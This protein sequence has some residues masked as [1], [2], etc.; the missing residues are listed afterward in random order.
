[1]ADPNPAPILDRIDHA[2]ARIEAAAAARTANHAALVRRHETLRTRMAEAVGAL[3]A[4]IA[5]ES[6]G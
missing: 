5:R 2:L 6:D 4:V 1:M 3:D